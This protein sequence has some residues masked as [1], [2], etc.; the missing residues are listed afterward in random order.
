MLLI[1]LQNIVWK[2]TLINMKITET[3]L[4][5][6]NVDINIKNVIN[7]SFFLITF[8]LLTIKSYFILQNIILIKDYMYESNYSH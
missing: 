5:E 6:C 1:V 3:F 8:E 2:E 4:M 7:K